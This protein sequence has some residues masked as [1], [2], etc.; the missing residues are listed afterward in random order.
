MSTL[1]E[2][3]G[4]PHIQ[5]EL[6][7]GILAQGASNKIPLVDLRKNYLRIKEEVD[8]AIG[9]V[10]Q[11]CY[12]IGSP[13]VKKF[14]ANFAKWIGVKHCVG[15][16]SGTDALVLAMKFLGIGVGDEV[17]TQGNTFI[18]T[19]LG[20]SNNGADVVLVDNDQDTYMIDTSKIEERI[21]P[22]T[23]AI[24]V[25]HLYGHMAEM[26][27]ILAIAKKHNLFVIE[28][29]AQA[30]GASYKGKRAGSFGDVGCFSFYP[31]KNMGA[32]GD[33]G[34]VVTNNDTVAQKL[35]WWQS[36]GAKKKY[37][38]EIKGGNSRLDSI[39]A[40]VLDVKL[41]HMDIFNQERSRHA[42]TYIEL[43][44]KSGLN[45]KLPVV[46]KDVN[47]VW[48]L[49]VIQVDDRDNVQKYLNS[50]GIG[51][52][53]H[54]PIPIHRLNAYSE[55][56]HFESELPNATSAAPKLLSLPIYPELENNEINRIVST[57]CEYYTRPSTS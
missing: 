7:Q 25:V 30:H 47:P 55:L 34:A 1:A 36:W 32:F 4:C 12:F 50:K 33:G 6:Q 31:G 5:K 10:L 24:V 52:G 41:R 22:K 20:I 38:H 56:M 44:K 51:A 19:C 35:R 46:A 14:E 48:H 45:I 3:K 42:K 23:K 57:L 8:A 26:D 21:T 54:Y 49:F 18:A 13:H 43:I 2:I 40:A 27:T 28:D 53:I 15:V 37:H 17:I 39:Q 29:A 11:S 9:N 16:N